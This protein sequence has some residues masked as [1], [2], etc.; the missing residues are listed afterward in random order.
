MG[1]SAPLR[2]PLCLGCCSKVNQGD[3]D[4][5]FKPVV[6]AKT[7]PPACFSWHSQGPATTCFWRPRSGLFHR[8]D[9]LARERRSEER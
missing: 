9:T 5:G 2:R 8:V 3:A 6:Y 4:G 7:P 1:A